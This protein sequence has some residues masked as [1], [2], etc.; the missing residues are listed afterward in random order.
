[1][2]YIPPHKRHSKDDNNMLLPTQFQKKAG[3]SS[4]SSESKA[5]HTKDRAAKLRLSH[6]IHLQCSIS[7]WFIEADDDRIPA[8]SIQLE[9]FVGY[10][11][12]E[13]E[14][15][16]VPFV[17]NSTPWVSITEKIRSE[18]LASFDNMRYAM[19]FGEAG[20]AMKTTSVARIGK[21][22]FHNPS[23]NISSSNSKS[24]AETA[25]ARV[26]KQFCAKLTDSYMETILGGDFPKIIA[27]SY[28]PKEYYR[29]NVSVKLE[30][31][32]GISIKCQII[33][34]ELK[35]QKIEKNQK[36]C[37]VADVSC[38]HKD[39][40]LRLMLSTKRDL[41][42]AIK[43]EELKGLKHLVDSAILDGNVKGGLR[44][45]MGKEHSPDGR[46]SV[47]R[48]W[49]S[50]IKTFKSASLKLRF[51][52]ANRF[53]FCTSDGEVGKELTLDMKGVN[54]IL[55]DRM[56]EM[57]P[58]IGS[59]EEILKLVWSHLLSFEL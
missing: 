56:V 23:V 59:I 16:G 3:S 26:R 31:E 12:V 25:L 33:C 57:E 10:R 8:D 32:S 50:T 11:S 5:R 49:H 19:D 9:P 51:I 54:D 15:G 21:I 17:L 53:D 40:D 52:N 30:P 2:A 29:V 48:A 55:M 22:L 43:D 28:Q 27:D 42:A 7:K 44:W 1:M 36:R 37:F 41:T 39:L 18:L 6:I 47:V 46:Y 20:V 45:S 35:I 34:G 38:L 13:W 4:S 14:R 24:E 58:G